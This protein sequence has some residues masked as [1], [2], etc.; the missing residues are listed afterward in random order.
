MAGTGARWRPT[1]T[2]TTQAPGVPSEGAHQQLR[3]QQDPD[4]KT[5]ATM[6]DRAKAAPARK[7]GSAP[8]RCQPRPGAAS[9]TDFNAGSP[10]PKCASPKLLPR[11]LEFHRAIPVPTRCL[12][13]LRG[14]LRFSVAAKAFKKRVCAFYRSLH[15]GAIIN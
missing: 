11:S 4:S 9:S 6:Q 10:A 8:G 13:A 5:G 15:K 1:G 3:R 7:K 2:V 12:R 14:R